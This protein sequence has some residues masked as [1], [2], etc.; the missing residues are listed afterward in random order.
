V[1]RLVEVIEPIHPKEQVI[2]KI[3]IL[4]DELNITAKDISKAIGITETAM[5]K[6][7][8]GKRDLS[9]EEAQKMINYVSGRASIIPHSDG[10]K[11]YA[12]TFSKVEWAYNDETVAEVASRM[13]KKGFSQLP[14]KNRSTGGIRGIVSEINILKRILHPEANEKKIGSLEE[15]KQLSIEEAGVI[16]DSPKYSI[17]SKMVE[18]S[19]VLNNYYAVLLTRGDSITST[20]EVVGIM[21]R[22]DILKLLI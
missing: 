16:E 14:V 22:A 6:V 19:P 20:E 4:Q 9:Y 15:M 11:K 3:K 8:T 1:V 12:T 2:A 10:V 7:F 5:S 21:T 13:F 17:G 18:V